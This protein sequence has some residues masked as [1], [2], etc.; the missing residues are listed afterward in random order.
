MDIPIMQTSPQYEGISEA[1]VDI[2]D[3]LTNNPTLDKRETPDKEREKINIEL[4]ISVQI[5]QIEV[6]IFLKAK[7]Y[8]GPK[9]QNT[10]TVVLLHKT[11]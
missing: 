9:L 11:Y 2:K 4:T 10:M 1:S 5:S 7:R 6:N 3:T 8:R